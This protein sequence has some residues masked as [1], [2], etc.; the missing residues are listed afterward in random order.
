M[1]KGVINL[2]DFITFLGR[3]RLLEALEHWGLLLKVLQL[4]KKKFKLT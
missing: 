3:V 2:L 1:V 4:S